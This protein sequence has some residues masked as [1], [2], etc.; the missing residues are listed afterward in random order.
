MFR[1]IGGPLVT[2]TVKNPIRLQCRKHGFDPWVKMIPWRR[3]WQ[4]IP[5][6]LPRELH[7][8]RRLVD[9]SPWGR[10]ESDTYIQGD[11]NINNN[12]C[13]L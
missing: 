12:S 3:E 5:V 6:F 2:Q 8:Q 11:S 4:P 1:V 7:G 9:Y 13:H 10:K